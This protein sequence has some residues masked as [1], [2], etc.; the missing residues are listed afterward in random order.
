ML[1]EVEKRDDFHYCNCPN[2]Q[3]TTLTLAL[4]LKERGLP[5]LIFEQPLYILRQTWHGWSSIY[6]KIEGARALDQI[7]DT[8]EYKALDCADTGLGDPPDFSDCQWD[9]ET[10]ARVLVRYWQYRAM[11]YQRW[12][13][14]IDPK[15]SKD[16]N[17][18]DEKRKEAEKAQA[19]AKELLGE[20]NTIT[21]DDI[22]SLLEEVVDR[23]LG[24]APR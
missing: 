19:K 2:D 6:T 22:R 3:P 7:K 24:S 23:V 13:D 21:P 10:K 17:E 15:T 5:I 11:H 4:L 14:N 9:D 8:S 16:V 18:K 12:A 1:P 20:L